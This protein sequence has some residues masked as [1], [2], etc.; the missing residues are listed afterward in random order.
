MK[1]VYEVN[2][3]RKEYQLKWPIQNSSP[4]KNPHILRQSSMWMTRR[5]CQTSYKILYL[6]DGPQEFLR[7]SENL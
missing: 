1:L 5:K 7:A 4:A 2:G 3:L 6:R